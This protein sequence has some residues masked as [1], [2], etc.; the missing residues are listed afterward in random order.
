M[1]KHED[2]N[3]NVQRSRSSYQQ[4]GWLWPALFSILLLAAIIMSTFTRL[5]RKEI[6]DRAN[7]VER[8]PLGRIQDVGYVTGLG[9]K[10]VYTRI[11][12][13]K[14]HVICVRSYVPAPLAS[15]GYIVRTRTGHTY[16]TWD[17][18]GRMYVTVG[19]PAQVR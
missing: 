3:W 15:R 17:G 18:A 16:F 10:K 7:I 5:R 2:M 11:R 13:D 14:R 9:W 8:I 19:S 4:Q 6:Q 12:T 1:Q